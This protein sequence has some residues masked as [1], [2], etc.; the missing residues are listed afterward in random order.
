MQSSRIW[1]VSRWI[2]SSSVS[3]WRPLKADTSVNRI[4]VLVDVR[5]P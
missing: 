4:R 1:L 2:L 3:W 5:L